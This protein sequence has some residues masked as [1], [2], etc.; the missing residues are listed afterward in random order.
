MHR[1]WCV[2]SEEFRQELLLQM[3]TVQGSK[4]AGPEWTETGQKKAERMV[5]VELQQ[6]GWNFDRLKKLRKGWP[7]EAQ[8]CHPAENRDHRN[9]QVD[10]GAPEHGRTGLSFQLPQKRQN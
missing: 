7:G 5:A 10:R 1:G 2:D 8:D 4:F 6:R 9:V 3:T